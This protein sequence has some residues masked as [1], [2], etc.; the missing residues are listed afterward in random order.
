MATVLKCKMCGGDIEVSQ[1]MTVG[2]CLYCGSTMTL[3]R[4][5]SEKKARLF[6]RANQ[7]RLN[8]EFDKAYDA[9]RAIVDEDEQEAEAYWGLILSEY[10]V[11]YVED[12]KTGKRIP[13]CHRT[14][15]QSI[16][17]S[18]NYK[19][20]LQFADAES[21]FIY[22]DEA[23]VLDKLQK[24]IISVSA[25]EE[26]Y[27]VFI[28]YK[29]SDEQ[30]GERTKDSVLAQQLYDA[31]QEKGIRTFFARISLEDKVGQNYEPFIYAAL[32]SARVM[33]LVTT[34]NAHCNAIWV[35]NEWMRFI[36]FMEEDKNKSII[37]ACQEMSPY[38]LPDEL[39]AYQAQD[40]GKVGAVQDLVYGITKLLGKAPRESNNEIINELLEEKNS[41]EKRT[42][43]I[44]RG[45]VFALVGFV[46]FFAAIIFL[47]SPSFSNGYVLLGFESMA[48]RFSN[49]LPAFLG[50]LAI[51]G[52]IDI[53][54]MIYGLIKGYTKP[55]TKRM[56]VIGFVL[57]N[58]AILIMRFSGFLVPGILFIYIVDLILVVII[59]LSKIRRDRRVEA[60]LRIVVIV[61]CALISFTNIGFVKEEIANAS[62]VSSEN[63]ITV[64]DT[65]ANIRAQ[66][67]ST[68]PKVGEVYKGM[69]FD[70]LDAEEAGEYTWY[71]ICTEGGI[72]GYVRG[73]LVDVPIKILITDDYIN[74]R[75]GAGTSY[76]K[77]GEVYKGEQYLAMTSQKVGNRTWYQII[78]SDGTKG[79]I[80]AE[81]IEE[82]K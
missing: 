1:D 57:L 35:K 9:Y 18:V 21:K 63:Q 8:N 40:M 11:E 72:E 60:I 41:R 17:S 6:N 76:D 2:T 34:S 45:L 52:L 53:T 69:V 7:Y 10:G 78:L 4:I 3:P 31:L 79:Y 29:E 77:I 73:D 56:L 39:A 54:G 32:K 26:P 28:C 16:T 55:W 82:L 12:P 58:L 30:T 5:E 19:Q 70:V 13:T 46:A 24:N 64:N 62:V 22:Q 48:K 47:G 44:I 51:A 67:D 38:E 50:I 71:R 59:T 20:A 65:F 68:S 66:A 75:N 74:V 33:V 61:V 37:P 81:G 25:K 27:D 14:R 36:Q 80:G 42:S 49:A 15:V 43:F 23:E